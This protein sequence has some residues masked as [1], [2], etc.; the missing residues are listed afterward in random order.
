MTPSLV[1]R[2]L[3][4]LGSKGVVYCHWKS[5]ADL[6][7]A[8]A[9]GEELDLLVERKDAQ[10]FE[11]AV[12]ALGFKR[13]VDLLHGRFA[14]VFHF[15]GLD[16]NTCELVHLHVYYRMTTGESLLKNYS[17]PLEELFLRHSRLVEGVRLPPPAAE[18]MLFVIRAMLKHASPVEYLLLRRRNRSG[19]EALRAELEYLLADDAAARCAE[20]LAEWL[21]AV[22]RNLF[23]KCLE[24]IRKDAPFV[25]RF[26]LALRLR[27]QLEAYKRSSSASAL[28]QLV[29]LL[30]RQALWRWQGRR[31]KQPASGGCVIAF[32]GPEATG[33]S[34]LV[35][36][37]A[38]W[39]GKTFDVTSA[40]LGKPPSTWLTFLPNMALSVARKAVP[41]L[42]PRLAESGAPGQ[43][44][45]R[46]SLLYSLRAV[47]L[48]WDRRALALRLR[49]KAVNGRIVICDRYPSAILGAMDSARLKTPVERGRW[50]G[51][52]GY[53][54]K[55]ENQLYRQ[56]PPP[57]AVIQLTVPVEVAV[58]RNQER[59]QKD[60]AAFV[61][62][63]HTAVM[64][65]TFPTAKTVELNSNQPRSQTI[66][67]ARQ[68]IWDAL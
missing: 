32:V 10:L 29:L 14:S 13:V 62:H 25:R 27:G 49:R 57:D 1:E 33:K 61:V 64:V 51:L 47:I 36:E 8:L 66:N 43:P 24:A 19:Y 28:L 30:L 34:T 9:K 22:D 5:N 44:N 68:I 63:R 59:R 46:A 48:A 35:K 6:K 56:I 54:A 39:L 53:L 65:P 58:Q 12:A 37:T 40:H 55:G 17:F 2:L 21:P 42:R 4:T 15:Y 41:F 60:A 23:Y 52:L 16:D 11:S 26:W 3:E 20:L 38:G 31:S 7:E 45:R 18:L 67:S 50:R